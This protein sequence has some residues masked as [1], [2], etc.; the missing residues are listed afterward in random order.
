MFNTKTIKNILRDKNKKDNTLNE[1]LKKVGT[2]QGGQE[3]AEGT[4]NK[5]KKDKET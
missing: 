1:I 5:N 2:I 3:K 4:K